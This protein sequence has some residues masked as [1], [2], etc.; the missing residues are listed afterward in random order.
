MIDDM[1]DAKPQLGI[2]AAATVCPKCGYE[3]PGG[4]D[5]CPRCGLLVS[6]WSGYLAPSLEHPA[7]D[8]LWAKVEADWDDDGPHAR[9]LD[10]AATLGA[11]DVAAAHYRRRLLQSEAAG[12][13]ARAQA[14]V[15][16]A[17]R[18][19][20]EIQGVQAP[21]PSLG[22]LARLIK[23]AGIFIALALFVATLWVVWAA[24]GR[25]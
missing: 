2:V 1:H 20:L 16:R 22:N 25:R 13:D 19:A 6:R 9:F 10:Q 3:R 4:A 17:V 12:G 5:A 24:L 23:I 21:D 7:L 14:G 11:L 15:D 18:L 8:V